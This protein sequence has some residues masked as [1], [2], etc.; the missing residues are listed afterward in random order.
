MANYVY[1]R[2]TV[3]RIGGTFRSLLPWATRGR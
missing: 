1:S 2:T 3:E